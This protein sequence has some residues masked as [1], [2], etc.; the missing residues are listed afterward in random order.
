MGREYNGEYN[1]I[2]NGVLLDYVIV[3]FMLMMVFLNININYVLCHGNSYIEIYR[4]SHIVWYRFDDR[5]VCKRHCIF[6]C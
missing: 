3:I 2:D 6:L 5:A 4:R 1:G